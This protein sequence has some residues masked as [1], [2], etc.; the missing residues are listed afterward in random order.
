MKSGKVWLLGAG[1]GDAGLLTIKARAV[2]EQADVVVYDAL[3]GPGVLA[4]VPETARLINVGKRAGN[5][6]VPQEEIN[7]ILLEEAQA[8]HRVARLKGGDPFVF[9][10][11]GEE[12]EL[13]L[14]HGVPFEVVPGVT[15]AVAVPAYAGIPVTHRECASSVHFITGHTRNAG[16]EA[17]SYRA[18]A[19]LGGTLVFLMG[20]SALP[21]I[22]RGLLEAGMAP[23]MP[24]AVLER[25]TTARQRRVVSTLERL[26][27]DA[28]EGCIAPPAIIVVGQVCALSGRFHWAEDRPLGGARIVVTRP[29]ALSGSLSA[30]LRELGAEVLEL[31][32]LK[33]QLI[34]PNPALEQALRGI[35]GYGWLA[36]TSPSGAGH[37]LDGLRAAGMDIRALAGVRLAAVGA[38]TKRALEQ[39]GLHCEL[40][41]ERYNAP[42]L[43]KLLAQRA[44]G[45]RVLLLR[46][47]EASPGL[48]QTLAEAGVAYDDIPLYETVSGGEAMPEVAACIREG[49]DC[50]AFASASAVRGFLS[51]MGVGFDAASLKAVCIGEQTAREARQAGMQVSTAKTATV[52]AL[53]ACVIDTVTREKPGERMV[54]ETWSY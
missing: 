19:E 40:M 45:K 39:H 54:R 49:V 2:L 24:A 35:S 25:G 8:G 22:R 42:E 30:R 48:T 10:R 12:L 50:A 38:A 17:A 31:P 9:G 15:S 13:L 6:P 3:V 52:E 27:L 34:W 36:V 43:G 16:H 51:A 7:R 20:V 41:P 37:L 53:V 23:S 33:T 44:D 28:A 47:R 18:L 1:P 21:D 29:R 14:E 4:M 32:A 11:G 46:A 5:H 26:E